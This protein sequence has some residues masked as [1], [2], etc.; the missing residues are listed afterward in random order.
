MKVKIGN[1]IYD[2]SKEPIMLILSE[3]DKYNISHMRLQDT[4]YLSYPENMSE[5]KAKEF[6]Q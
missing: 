6:M 5:E 3:E 1:T 4:K 2:G